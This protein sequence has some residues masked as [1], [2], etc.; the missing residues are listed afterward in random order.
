MFKEKFVENSQERPIIVI[1]RSIEAPPEAK[2]NP[3]YDSEIWGNA[4][5]PDN[6]YLPESDEAISFALAAHEIGHLVK[7]GEIEISLDDFEATRAEEMRAWEKGWNYLQKYLSEYYKDQTEIIPVIQEAIEK[8]QK[9]MMQATDLSQG[10]Y[11]EKGSLIGL[12]DEEERKILK[13]RRQKFFTEKGIEILEIYQQIKS[14]NIGKKVDW[15]KYV[16]I[17]TKTVQEILNDNKK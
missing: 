4:K 17:I 12:S 15:E 1:K 16:E 11:L 8:I 9:L 13:E 14:V 10:L 2:E 3:F 7:E 5:S 6:I